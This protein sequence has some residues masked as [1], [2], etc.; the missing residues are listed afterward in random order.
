MCTHKALV[1]ARGRQLTK[2]ELYRLL[3]MYSVTCLRHLIK[4]LR[5]KD[6]LLPYFDYSYLAETYRENHN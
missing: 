3:T 1:T 5:I 2:S 4:V 6:E